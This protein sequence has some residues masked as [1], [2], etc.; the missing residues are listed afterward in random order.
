MHKSNN[1]LK[2]IIRRQKHK[3]F[4]AYVLEQLNLCGVEKKRAL[5]EDI[6]MYLSMMLFHDT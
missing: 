1:Q 5:K 6:L 3:R 4:K 2:I